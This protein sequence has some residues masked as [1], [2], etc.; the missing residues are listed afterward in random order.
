MY[1]IALALLWWTLV[2]R[3]L[4][5]SKQSS[6]SQRQASPPLLSFPESGL[7]DSAAYHGYQ[8]RFYRDASGNTLQIYLDGRSGRVVHLWADAEDESVGVTV[9][10]G[11]GQP[12]PLRWS[13]ANPTVSTNGRARVFEYD[14]I[15]D[16]ARVD[17]GLFLLGSMRVE[18]DFQYADR[19]RQAF[20]SAPF[21]LPEMDRL[22]AALERLD[23]QQRAR[24]L[25]LL[26][27]S[28]LEQVRSRL[29]PVITTRREPTAWTARVVQPSLDARDTLT[30]EVRADS[31]RL[32]ASQ[33]GGVVSLTNGGANEIPFTLRISTT[34]RPLSPLTRQE[35]FTPEFLS[36]LAATRRGDSMSARSRWL[37]REVRGVELLSSREKLMAGLPAYAT[38]FGRDMLVSALMMRPIWRADMSA[39]AI[40]SALRKLGPRGEVSHEEAMGGQ[41]DREAANEYADLVGASLRA[42]AGGDRRAADSLLAGA[43]TVLRE[44]RR[45]RENYHMIDNEFQLPVLEA[46]WLAD[47]AVSAEEKR[48][49]LL[50]ATDGEP[51]VRRMLR[52]LALVARLTAA[53][54]AD[55]TATHLI[56]FA[57]RDGGWASAS[58]R[59][60]NEGYA[61]GRY[62]MD[63]NAIWAP[64]ALESMVGILQAL[65]TIGLPPDSIARTM[66]ELEPGTALGGYVREPVRLV[67]A[68]DVWR[69]AARHFVVT[70]GPADVQTRVRARLAALPDNERQHWSNV[71]ATS[72]ADRD[73]LSFL[74]LSLDAS[75][76]PIA[77]ANSDPATRLF[78]ANPR[79]SATTDLLRDIRLFVRPYPVGLVVDGVGPVVANDAYAPPPIWPQFER[80]KYHGP[81]VVW[82]REVNLFLLG[83]LKQLATVR[84]S[85]V[86]RE[87]LSALDVVRTSVDASG[88]HSELWSYA[89]QDDRAVPV[90]YGT[91]SDV[92]LWSTTDLAVQ[93]A[94]FK[95]RR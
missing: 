12:A 29:R 17:L 31:R 49:F 57:P 41:A 8:T 73:S 82:G 22:L 48:A 63:V 74:A 86:S 3:T 6:V 83:V 20:A 77:V 89:V 90:R 40:A 24:H 53:Y 16:A 76:R 10:D 94:L 19:H 64:N 91:G 33:T 81:R 66:P 61:G 18:R 21:A 30:L 2:A 7:D 95:L 54:V 34:G 46:S 85:T 47:P 62:A 70:F 25:A 87:L 56:S 14:L 88:F 42:R 4:P 9:R 23:P 65:R 69:S 60:S 35:I 37:E 43:R 28:S 92:Q 58:W 51:H 75:G 72:R 36:F 27:T 67:H 93:Y 55:S 50:D 5:S 80:D 13:S 39:F 32:G 1:P 38:Y 84:D 45:V 79:D 78:L 11:A 71:I 15:A 52:Q 44:H 26:H 59:D 68:V